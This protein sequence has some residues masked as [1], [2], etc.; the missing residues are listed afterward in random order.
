MSVAGQRAQRP[1]QSSMDPDVILKAIQF[2]H[3]DGATHDAFNIRF[4]EREPVIL[5]EWRRKTTFTAQQSPAAYAIKERRGNTLTIKVRFSGTAN[6]TVLVRAVPARPNARQTRGCN[7][8]ARLLPTS[9]TM[10]RV[11]V[12]GEIREREIRFDANGETDLE[13]FE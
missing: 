10:Q 3:R 8:F 12:L 6:S 2:N 13:D 11:N 9:S 4:N 1:R 5:P 7:P